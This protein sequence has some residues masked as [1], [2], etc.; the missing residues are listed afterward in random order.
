M[1]STAKVSTLRAN[2]FSIINCT[3]FSCRIACNVPFMYGE[4]LVNE[5]A[6]QGDYRITIRGHWK[7]ELPKQIALI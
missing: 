4:R 7:N 5:K 1:K 3:G 2:G 6:S